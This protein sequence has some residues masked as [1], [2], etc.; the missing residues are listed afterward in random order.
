[1]SYAVRNLT[2][3]S[4]A[5][6]RS[7]N[8]QSGMRDGRGH[9]D[10]LRRVIV[11]K[12]PHLDEYLA[13]WMLMSTLP[14]DP[15]SYGYLEQSIY[16]REYDHVA[17]SLW[18]SSIV[19]GFGANMS[20]LRRPLHCFDEHL[21]DG[22]RTVRSA[23]RL[24]YNELFSG[25]IKPLVGI[26]LILQENDIIDSQ[27]GS[28]SLHLGNLIKLL[29]TSRVLVSVEGQSRTE[30]L[31]ASWK[32]ATVFACLASM[33]YLISEMG[34]WRD[35]VT[36]MKRV[37][38]RVEAKLRAGPTATGCNEKSYLK[39]KGF[40]T[41]WGQM[42]KS[43]LLNVSGNS[44]PQHLVL[45]RMAQAL[46]T[47]FFDAPD[48]V[49]FVLLTLLEPALHNQIEFDLITQFLDLAMQDRKTI[50]GTNLGEFSFEFGTNNA[51][52]PII[53]FRSFGS[54]ANASSPISAFLNSKFSGNGIAFVTN[55]ALAT[56]VIKA[57]VNFCPN[58][59]DKFCS[60]LM[61]SEPN[62]W[63]RPGRARFILNG[64]DTHRYQPATRLTTNDL[65]GIISSL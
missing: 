57:G 27:G 13:D 21:P 39:F 60:K 61:R 32:R 19:L 1:M 50:L 54:L 25:G 64:N 10:A 8:R 47:C 9:L 29:H 56:S 35:D 51:G 37:I 40:I 16:S 52:T 65:S 23:S 26:R 38:S 3:R 6:L 53:G 18:P 44:I 43:N 12:A 24:V 62:A 31:P 15:S 33:V 28:H 45:C 42:C 4:V 36:R 20:K 22:S 34:N 58:N 14:N 2:D 41:N 11:H 7:L 63:F 49:D 17:N 59:W 48:T 5:V 46:D 30:Q 55:T